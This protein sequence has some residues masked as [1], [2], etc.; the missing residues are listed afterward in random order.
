VQKKIYDYLIVDDIQR[1]V[2]DLRAMRE[3][4]TEDIPPFETR[5]PGKL[6]SILNQIQSELFGKELYPGVVRKAAWLFYLMVKNH[7][8]ANGNK[9]IAIITLFQFLKRNVSELYIG[10]TALNGG[11]YTMAIRTSESLPEDREKIERY[12][13]RKIRSFIIAF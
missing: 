4:F 1:I 3:E 6:E 13:R 12:L 5:Y 7:P 8:F 10:Q 9:R 11:L 2:S